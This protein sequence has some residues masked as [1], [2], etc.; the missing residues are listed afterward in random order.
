M[1]E[2]SGFSFAEIAVDSV[3]YG[4]DKL[5]VY[6]LPLSMSNASIGCRVIVPFG[7]SS[8]KRQGIIMRLLSETSI[9]N[10]RPVYALLD[11]KPILSKEQMELV[12]YLKQTTYC[13]YFD[14][15]KAIL[16][17]GLNYRIFDTYSFNPDYVDKDKLSESELIIFNILSSST[18]PMKITDIIL[19]CTF[20]NVAGILSSLCE[21]GAV[22][23]STSSKR[24]GTD[25]V[26]NICQLIISTEKAKDLIASKKVTKQGASV[27][28]YLIDNGASIV[29]DICY[30][31]GVSQGVINTL[32]RNNF[33]IIIAEKINRNPHNNI[34]PSA[35]NVVLSEE[36]NIVFNGLKNLYQQDK[37]NC[38]LLRGVTGSGKTEVFIALTRQVISDGKDVIVLVPEI[39]LTPQT[40]GKFKKEFGDIVAV[41]H[42]SLSIGERMDEYRR[43][44][45]GEAKIAVGTRSAIFAPLKNIGLIVID[46]EQVSSYYSEQSPRYH[47][48]SIAKYLAYRNNALLLLAS[49][50]PSIP[51]Y[52]YAKTGKYSLF[53]LDSRYGTNKLP[54]VYTADMRKELAAGNNTSISSMLLNELKAN[55]DNGEQ[56][57]VLL[58]R[59]GYHTVG[60]C[61]ECGEALKCD[62]CDI[63]LTYHSANN[64]LMC[65]YCGASKEYTEICPHCG[66]KSIHYKGAGTQKAYE[67]LLLAIPGVRILRMDL[68]TTSS[69]EAHT[70]MLTE[71]ANGKY[72]ILLGT[73]MV[74]KGLDFPNVTLVG[75]MS[76]D[77][78]LF[79]DD[80]RADERTF[81]MMTQV[82]GRSGRHK[83]GRAVVQTYAPNHPVL[84]KAMKQDY[85]SFYND[86]ILIRKQMLYPPFCDICLISI[87]SNKDSNCENAAKYIYD[88]ICKIVNEMYSDLPIKILHPNRELMFKISSKYRFN[89]VL[90]CKDGKKFEAFL[91]DLL[92]RLHKD[93][94]LSKVSIAAEINPE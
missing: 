76:A 74:A 80:F 53:E 36:Q 47:A 52:Y 46:E 79:D 81:S 58:N 61:S 41:I 2:F 69:K 57:I 6:S 67:E 94:K 71:F 42:S 10:T 55:I 27:L 38:A 66:T 5:Y 70:K 16:P 11:T 88:Y 60:V 31:T 22:I 45:S 72:D 89:L 92:I 84:V 91:S 19:N 54:G 9:S 1:T 50:T 33:V 82:I 63:P 17:T 30:F 75:V 86:D 14:A 87:S 12:E 93:T 90:K 21:K 59:R 78:S 34:K 77:S 15:V 37:P 65:H 43:L 29:K 24:L 28:N 64:R 68:D 44:E 85:I 18:K 35:T 26:R 23:C 25:A 51:T 20:D 83:A 32:I 3:T 4:L 49:A 73:Q 13:T 39:T 62:N 8:S 40:V 7:R 48:H 56:S